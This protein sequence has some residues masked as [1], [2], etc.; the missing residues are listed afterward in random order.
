MNAIRQSRTKA[1][2]GA[3]ILSCTCP[4]VIDGTCLLI[5]SRS[6]LTAQKIGFGR[7]SGDVVSQASLSV[8]SLP[9]ASAELVPAFDIICQNMEESGL[10]CCMKAARVLALRHST[11]QGYLKSY[12]SSSLVPSDSGISFTLHIDCESSSEQLIIHL[13]DYMIDVSLAQSP[14]TSV[15]ISGA[16]LFYNLSEDSQREVQDSKTRQNTAAA[17]IAMVSQAFELISETFLGKMEFR[18]YDEI[19]S[20]LATAVL[21]LLEVPSLGIALQKVK[22]S[23]RL[24]DD[25]KGALRGQASR[26]TKQSLTLGQS[27]VS[28]SSH[29]LPK[30]KRG[31]EQSDIWIRDLTEKS[32]PLPLSDD[33][34]APKYLGS[35]KYLR[36]TGPTDSEDKTIKVRTRRDYILLYAPKWIL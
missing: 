15:H 9:V 12:N 17:E 34:E 19:P 26:E 30:G 14:K 21:E 16:R 29:A 4:V 5:L 31:T 8:E 10:L 36:M 32:K 1:G 22:L 24:V 27:D 7:M 23:I 35:K 13:P 3:L 18:S 28:P 25:P 6:E 2:T 33:V 11:I 20:R